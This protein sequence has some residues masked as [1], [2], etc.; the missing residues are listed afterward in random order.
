MANGSNTRL[1]ELLLEIGLVDRFTLD[2][3]RQI[4][5]RTGHRLG[6]VLVE[7]HLVEEERYVRAL[8]AALKLESVSLAT[9]KVHDRVLSRV[10]ARIARQAGLLPIAIKRANQIDYLYVVMSD[11]LDAETVAEIQRLTGC[12]LSLLVAPPTQLE[13]SIERYYPNTPAKA[14]SAN[15]PPAAA[16]PASGPPKPPVAP[17]V[18]SDAA[19][20]SLNP[21]TSRGSIRQSGAPEQRIV[22]GSVE[23]EADPAIGIVRAKVGL[24]PAP[25]ANMALPPMNLVRGDSDLIRTHIDPAS[26]NDP[27]EG[28]LKIHDRATTEGAA[29]LDVGDKVQKN[30]AGAAV[31]P[32]GFSL[33]EIVPASAWDDGKTLDVDV[34]EM[35]PQDLRELLAPA[36]LQPLSPSGD[37]EARGTTN[38]PLDLNEIIEDGEPRTSELDLR[39]AERAIDATRRKLASEPPASLPHLPGNDFVS[40]MELPVDVGDRPSP[41]DGISGVNLPAGLERTGIIPMI[42]WDKEEFEPP[43][44]EPVSGPSKHLIGGDDIPSSPAEVRARADRADSPIPAPLLRKKKEALERGETVAEME[45]PPMMVPHEIADAAADELPDDVLSGD[46]GSA[47][48]SAPTMAARETLAP[49]AP[50]PLAE[51]DEEVVGPAETTDGE[52]EIVEDPIEEESPAKGEEVP[53]NPR[54]PPDAVDDAFA[55]ERT[56]AEERIQRD[57]VLDELEPEFTALSEG[58]ERS[59]KLVRAMLEGNSLTSADRAQLVLGIGRLLIRNGVLS[60]DDLAA[61]L[62]E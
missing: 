25:V 23:P 44:L 60:A 43:P 53:T 48:P 7:N 24:E 22:R 20:R 8:S 50:E 54:I 3:A 41:F 51:V 42:D 21:P 39:A 29:S 10:P 11:P 5:K 27:A 1:G 37:A 36:G 55:A 15:G 4:Q 2:E 34:E 32:A 14:D 58:D 46:F 56:P 16:S 38:N 62:I 33:P 26:T 13:G 35:D 57:S 6:R 61:I 31:D 17:R 12:Q 52:L 30:L 47:Y 18:I 19:S 40:A 45:P 28:V 9:M 59:R 49:P